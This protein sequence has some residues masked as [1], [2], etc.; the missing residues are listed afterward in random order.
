MG[1]SRTK[2]SKNLG[3]VI[4]AIIFLLFIIATIIVATINR[5]KIV[6]ASIK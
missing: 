3:K 2:K 5:R 1:I 6:A 4:I